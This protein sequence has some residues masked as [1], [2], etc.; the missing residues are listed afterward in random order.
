MAAACLP[1]W[2]LSVVVLTIDNSQL[3][4]YKMSWPF[5]AI[6]IFLLNEAYPIMPV[7]REIVAFIVDVGTN[8]L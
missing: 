6:S 7:V 8:V 3:F 4:W 5:G 2:I 1:V